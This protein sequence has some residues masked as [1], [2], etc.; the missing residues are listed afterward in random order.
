MD[1]QIRTTCIWNSDNFHDTS[2]EM[3]LVCRPLLNLF[4][5]R[6]GSNR[7]STEIKDDC[8]I[9]IQGIKGKSGIQEGVLRYLI[10]S[11]SPLDVTR[12]LNNNRIV[13]ILVLLHIL[14]RFSV[15]GLK[16][17]PEGRVAMVPCHDSGA[18]HQSID[19]D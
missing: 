6:R 8:T 11:V 10:N 16:T 1:V 14:R 12:P 4:V 9:A 18:V 17:R 7:G 5:R 19:H 13:N 2:S 3:G 15:P